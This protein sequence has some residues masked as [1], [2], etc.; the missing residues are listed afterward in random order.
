MVLEE[1]ELKQERKFPAPSF[2]VL[3]SEDGDETLLA[4]DEQET[5][6]EAYPKERAASSD[7]EEVT[8]GELETLQDKHSRL[9]DRLE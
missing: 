6:V 8:E 7:V 1:Q 3:R 2:L 9:V 4:A 5:A